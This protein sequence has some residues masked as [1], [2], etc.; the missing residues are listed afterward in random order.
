MA[1]TLLVLAGCTST[2][3]APEQMSR[4]A[5]QTAPADLQLLCANAAAGPLGTT[6]EKIL[7]LSSKPINDKTFEV[8]LGAGGKKASCTVDTEG[9][10][11]SVRL[12]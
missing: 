4:T 10:V 9:N 8:E 6:S 11:S 3:P 2:T 5:V 7:P 1:A 12:I